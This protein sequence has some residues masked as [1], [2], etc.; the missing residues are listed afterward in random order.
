MTGS[1]RQAVIIAL[2]AALAA[3]AVSGFVVWQYV[4]RQDAV[5]NGGPGLSFVPQKQVG[6]PYSLVG[7]SGER[8]DSSAF[9]GEYQLI[10][11]G[12]TFCPDICP[13]EL[14]VMGQAVQTVAAAD[15][16]VAARIQPIFITVDPER[17]TPALMGEYVANFHDRMIGLTGSPEAIAKVAH[18]F[19]VY[20][21][22]V[23]GDDPENYLMDHSSFLYLVGPDDTLTAMLRTNGDPD[24]VAAELLRLIEG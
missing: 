24:A 9:A 6:A 12:Y 2:V 18:D 7:S 20:S 17:D 23:E 5:N 16:D 21:A 8:V 15:P 13:T 22:K 19:R 11:F 3:L 1:N 14:L 4:Q 10:Y